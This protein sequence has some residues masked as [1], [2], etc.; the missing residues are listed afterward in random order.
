MLNLQA[1]NPYSLFKN[2]TISF[3]YSNEYAEPAYPNKY[4]IKKAIV[5]TTKPNKDRD[6]ITRITSFKVAFFSFFG[7]YFNTFSEISLCDLPVM[8]SVLDL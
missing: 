4:I 5:N 2:D 3:M 8:F 1:N 7:T 6:N